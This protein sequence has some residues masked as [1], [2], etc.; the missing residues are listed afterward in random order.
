MSGVGEIVEEGLNDW[1]APRD[2][3]MLAVSGIGEMLKVGLDD[4]AAAMVRQIALVGCV[5]GAIIGIT[6]VVFRLEGVGD[7]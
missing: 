7:E 5:H 6:G 3:G 2:A 4:L 1:A